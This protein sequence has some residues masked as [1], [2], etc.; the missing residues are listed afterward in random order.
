MGIGILASPKI[1]KTATD[2]DYRT[3]STYQLNITPVM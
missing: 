1:L 3:P 2:E